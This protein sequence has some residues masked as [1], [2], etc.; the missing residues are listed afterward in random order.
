MEPDKEK[1][2]SSFL[3][4]PDLGV[5]LNGSLKIQI[6]LSMPKTRFNH[7]IRPFN[8][9][10]IPLCWLELYVKDA[11]KLVHIVIKSLYTYLPIVQTVLMWVLGIL[12]VSMVGTAALMV[13]FFPQTAF[14]DPFI[15]IDY[16][17]IRIIPMTAYF[18]PDLRISK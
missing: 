8:D 6:S 13:F 5:P 3:L 14:E 11:P 16:S 2:D 18:K 10:T 12:G 17:P 15:N 1:H 4:H 9:M 7:K